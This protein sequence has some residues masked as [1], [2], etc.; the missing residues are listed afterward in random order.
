MSGPSSFNASS[1]ASP[2]ASTAPTAPTAT[3]STK[4]PAVALRAVPEPARRAAPHPWAEPDSILA[5]TSTRAVDDVVVLLLADIQAAHRLWGWSRIVLRDGPLLKPGTVP[6]LRFAKALGSG[7]EGGFGLRPSGSR[8]GLLTVFESQA[9][10]DA[11]VATSPIVQGYAERST[12]FLVATLRA[13]SC[14]GSWG[15]ASIR[16]TRHAVPAGP[17]AALTRA[18]IRASKAITFW[19]HSPASERSLEQAAGCQL[20]VGLGEAPLLRQATFS[21]WDN[22]A[23]MDAYARSGAHLQALRGA[24]QGG[25][26][27]ES[28]FVRFVPLA[29]KGVWKGRR[30]G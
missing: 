12:E 2:S 28:M 22:Q 18:S 26:F 9:Q 7:H 16:P 24:Q 8:Q 21:L 6:G 11:F 4:T 20:A 25:W 19:R 15:G 23:A 14:R 13:T 10:A 30:Y 3:T 17:V 27:T 5:G 29:V 1:G